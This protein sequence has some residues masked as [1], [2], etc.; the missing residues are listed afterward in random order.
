MTNEAIASDVRRTALDV[1]ARHSG[2]TLCQ[3]LSHCSTP[4]TLRQRAKE[5]PPSTVAPEAHRKVRRPA[6]CLK[7]QMPGRVKPPGRSRFSTLFNVAAIGGKSPRFRLWNDITT[8]ERGR[9]ED[10]R[11]S[12]EDVR[13]LDRHS[14]AV[15][16]F[17]PGAVV[18][19]HALV[20]EEIREH[21]PCVARPLADSTVRD[22]V[23]GRRQAEVSLVDL[24]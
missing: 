7:T 14:N 19:P 10:A 13:S 2:L 3:N 18:V 6:R 5:E 20:A 22:D 21:E 1:P 8:A 12:S 11:D 4:G 15:A 24:S 23:V 9:Q 17:R 16:P